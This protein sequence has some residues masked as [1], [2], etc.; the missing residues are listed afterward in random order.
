MKIV[1]QNLEEA[2]Y[3]LL[4][5]EIKE[6][7]DYNNQ[8]IESLLSPSKFTLNNKIAQLLKENEELQSQCLHEYENGFCIYCCKEEPKN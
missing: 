2:N 6:K 4:G 7:I 8:M 5:K 3:N 1:A